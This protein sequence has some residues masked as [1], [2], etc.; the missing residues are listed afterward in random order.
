M[1]GWKSPGW[2]I[3]LKAA[4]IGSSCQPVVVS[5]DSCLIGRLDKQLHP[6]PGYSTAPTPMGPSC[7]QCHE[8][9]RRVQTARRRGGGRDGVLVSSSHPSPTP[10]SFLLFQQP[11]LADGYCKFPAFSMRLRP[12]LETSVAMINLTVVSSMHLGQGRWDQQLYMDLQLPPSIPHRESLLVKKQHPHTPGKVH[13]QSRPIRV[14]PESC[15]VD[16]WQL[17][18]QVWESQDKDH[19]TYRRGSSLGRRQS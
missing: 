1:W 4:A 9:S 3:S 10:L 18:A 15:F 2:C 16:S 5:T 14:F 12:V 6:S 17:L 13:N 7:L 19:S 11:L 8:P